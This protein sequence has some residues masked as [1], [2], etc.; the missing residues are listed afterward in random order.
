MI[1]CL[2][3]LFILQKTE[4]TRFVSPVEIKYQKITLS[5]R[6]K[7]G[8]TVTVVYE[9]VPKNSKKNLKVVFCSF[10]GIRLISKDTI[11]HYNAVKGISGK[12]SIDAEYISTPAILC[13]QVEGVYRRTSITRYLM[14]NKTGEYGTKK[15]IQ[16]NPP[17][18]YHF[19]PRS[20][21]FEFLVVN[22]EDDRWHKNRAIIDT[23]RNIAPEITDSL[24]LVLYSDIPKVTYP[25]TI[26]AWSAKA[27]YLLEQGWH[28]YTDTIDRETFLFQLKE[29]NQIREEENVRRLARE[30]QIDR[31]AKFLLWLVSWLV[32]VVV[33]LGVLLVLLIMRARAK[34][35]IVTPKRIDK[36]IVYAIYI[37]TI[38]IAV[39]FAWP[40]LHVNGEA[41]RAWK[42]KMRNQ[43]E[44]RR[45]MY[46]IKRLNLLQDFRSYKL[47]SQN[48][49]QTRSG[50]GVNFTYLDKNSSR[51]G[52]EYFFTVHV[53]PTT[54]GYQT[55]KLHY[56]P[57]SAID[58]FEKNKR[59]LS[60]MSKYKVKHAQLHFIDSLFTVTINDTIIKNNAKIPLQLKY[61]GKEDLVT[62][63]SLPSDFEE[64]SFPEIERLTSLCNMWGYRLKHSASINGT[65]LS[66]INRW[67]LTAFMEGS[68]NDT[69]H[70]LVFSDQL[71]K[72]WWGP[73]PRGVKLPDFIINQIYLEFTKA[74]LPP[75][76]SRNHIEVI[77]TS[78]LRKPDYFAHNRKDVV[79]AYVVF[80][81]ITG[82]DWLDELNNSK[83]AQ[84]KIYYEYFADSLRPGRII[85][86]PEKTVERNLY[87]RPIRQII[88]QNE[89]RDRLFKY[90]PEE[91]KFCHISI[92]L[93]IYKELSE[94]GDFIYLIGQYMSSTDYPLEIKVDLET[95]TVIENQPLPH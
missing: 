32:P 53:S 85:R 80:K 3:L 13:V 61:N 7:L 17:L 55:E 44:M 4:T 33:L 1:T 38:C 36:F 14:S 29:K 24:A 46:E 21:K 37:V 34:K 31:R 65:W 12:F 39:Y 82:V 2:I 40:Y 74:G 64:D 9:V 5:N 88:S 15:E 18:E 86:T 22:F 83:G 11:Y 77:S 6:P 93:N 75:E 67:H 19:N 58:K 72:H 84:F 16:F 66:N 87:L 25:E 76:Y 81:W 51:M 45:V 23:I 70:L 56:P 48:F 59:A 52:V 62:A 90:L 42:T 71:F 91:E 94:Y 73:A 63:Y 50:L 60:F 10:K 41:I 35:K 43:Q 69:L 92:E 57:M 27:A 49:F 68:G 26:T 89:A 30:Q 95:G 47:V 8:E 20:R 28:R 79:I 78:A 54:M